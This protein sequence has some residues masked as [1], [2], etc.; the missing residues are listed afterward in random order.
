MSLLFPPAQFPLSNC[1][2]CVAITGFGVKG[3]QRRG[4]GCFSF[5]SSSAPKLEV[6]GGL[7]RV[8]RAYER[9]AVLGATQRWNH[10]QHL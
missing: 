5:Y 8:G 9:I 2:Q 3:S 6:T 7:S 10:A 4:H 1:A